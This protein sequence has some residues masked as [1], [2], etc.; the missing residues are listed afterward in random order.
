MAV[1]IYQP[2]PVLIPEDSACRRNFLSR[3]SMVDNAPL[4]ETDYREYDSR[5]LF[6][7]VFRC[8]DD[9][10]V[11]AIGPPPVNLR[12]ELQKLR[13]TCDGRLL[14]HCKREYRNLCILELT[15]D[16]TT[17]AGKN[18]PLRFSFP[19]FDVDIEVPPP[20]SIPAEAYHLGLMTLQR[21]NPLLWILD[22]CRWHHR[23]HGVSRFV[24]YDNASDNL[25]GLAAALA[26]MGEE[27]DIVLV[28]WPFP[29]GTRR[30]HRNFFCQIGAQN[31]YLLRFGSADAWC[32]NLDIDEYLVASGEK[33]FK[34]Y[35]RDCES[36]GVVEML[37]DSFI[38]PPH[39]GQPAMANRRVGSYW[40][41][42]RKHEGIN[43]KFAFKPRKIEYVR[44]HMAYPKNRIFAKLLVWPR[45]FDRTYRFFYVSLRKRLPAKR[46]FRFFSPDQFAL[47]NLRPD[48]MFF[49]HFRGLNTNW[50]RNISEE[51]KAFDASRHV[52]DP[53]IGELY[54]RAG[55][56]D[57]N[58]VHSPST[59]RS[60]TC[61]RSG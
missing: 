18:L 25:D 5:T 56:N 16:Q 49:Y 59:G 37:F 13:I 19:S 61:E 40:F 46:I 55:L 52:S 42:N 22:W 47:R 9:G 43:L 44:Q 1:L 27:V 30:N 6:Y 36:N 32:L 50:N 20:L 7:D 31:H 48:E 38:V 17:H 21:N 14:P 12:N 29:Y 24:L 28:D 60:S 57:D 34:Q 2:T 45:L 41:R 53:L 39:Q 4:T 3:Q 26:P 11:V 23:L 33:T 54:V 35:L 15:C 8:N 10:N 51:I 58:G